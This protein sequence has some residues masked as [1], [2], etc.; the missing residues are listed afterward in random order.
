MT[1]SMPAFSEGQ[2][3]RHDEYG[4]GTLDSISGSGPRSVAT[5]V[6]EGDAGIRT[7]ILSHGALHPE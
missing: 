7:F 1:Q 4:F 6:F 5:V 3:V 2:R